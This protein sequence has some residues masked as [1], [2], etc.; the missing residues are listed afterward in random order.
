MV[1]EWF[2]ACSLLTELE[3]WPP[4]MEHV[5]L[6]FP[7][8]PHTLDWFL[9]KSLCSKS[10]IVSTISCH[11]LFF[12]INLFKEPPFLTTVCMLLCVLRNQMCSLIMTLVNAFRCYNY[13]MAYF[14]NTW[15][16]WRNI[17]P[18]FPKSFIRVKVFYSQLP[19]IGPHLLP[20]PLFFIKI[21]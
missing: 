7:K 14:Q 15:F 10:E 1:K 5:F 21:F 16:T 20:L 19:L 17:M 3:L 13:L 8:V 12:V 11:F 18:F 6:I 9:T 4:G 2:S